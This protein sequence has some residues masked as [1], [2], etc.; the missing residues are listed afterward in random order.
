[1]VSDKLNFLSPFFMELL[2][3]KTRYSFVKKPIAIHEPGVEITDFQMPDK[4]SDTVKYLP[5]ILKINRA[6]CL[7]IL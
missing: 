4:T 6:S 5:D 3:I 2:L 1:M 7:V